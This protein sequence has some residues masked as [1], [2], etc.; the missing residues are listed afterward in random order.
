MGSLNRSRD[1]EEAKILS[2]LLMP[3]FL[4]IYVSVK[5]PLIIFTVIVQ[6]RRSRK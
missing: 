5:F 3:T 6:Q 4:I 1:V 2:L